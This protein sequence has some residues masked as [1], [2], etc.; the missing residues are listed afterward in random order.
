MTDANV[1]HTLEAK[2]KTGTI[3]FDGRF[4]ELR[5]TGLGRMTVGKGSKRIPVRSITA[6]QWKPAGTMVR[7]FMQLTIAGGNERRS[8]PGKATVDAAKDENS[9][10]FGKDEQAQFETIRDAIEEAIAAQ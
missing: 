5:R 7:G 3:V 2:G 4:V 10:V 9:I 8:R 1:P 6:V